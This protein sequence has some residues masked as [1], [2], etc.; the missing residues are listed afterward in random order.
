MGLKDYLNKIVVLDTDSRWLY[1]GTLK[2]IEEDC[3]T[4]EDVDAHDLKETTTSRQN[5]LIEVNAHGLV[6][7]RKMVRVCKEKVVGISTLEEILEK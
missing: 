2:A 4:I 5:Y 1:I 3:Y 6:V 7:N